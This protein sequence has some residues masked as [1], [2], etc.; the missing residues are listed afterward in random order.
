MVDRRLLML[1][2]VSAMVNLGGRGGAKQ[3]TFL[4]GREGAPLTKEDKLFAQWSA[5]VSAW[6]SLPSEGA[7]FCWWRATGASCGEDCPRFEWEARGWSRTPSRRHLGQ[8]RS[9]QRG[10]LIGQTTQRPPLDVEVDED[11]ST[12]IAGT[13]S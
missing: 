5:G 3:L 4:S 2:W 13:M 12:A 7:T 11:L 8:R 6:K 1:T 9:V 10:R